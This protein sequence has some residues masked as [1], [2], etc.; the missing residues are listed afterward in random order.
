MQ[1]QAMNNELIDTLA[2][3]K[4]VSGPDAKGNYLA[5]C[6]A[7]DDGSPSLGIAAGEQVGLV[8]HCYAGCPQ[9]AVLA[10][11]R[12]LRGV[13][14]TIP[15]RSAPPVASSVRRAPKCYSTID[16]AEQ[17]L[18]RVLKGKV[19]TWVYRSGTGA[20][21]GAVVRIDSA[22]GKT[23]RPL[24]KGS[25][26]WSME[27]MREPR[28]LFQLPQLLASGVGSRV[29]I[30]EGERCAQALRELGLVAV[31]WAGGA[32]AVGKADWSPLRLMGS[33]PYILPDNDEAGE[34]AA[35][36][37]VSNLREHG[38]VVAHIVRLP[39]V[40]KGDD[41]I[42]WLALGGSRETLEQIAAASPAIWLQPPPPSPSN[43]SA[44][45]TDDAEREAIRLYEEERE[46]EIATADGSAT[47]RSASDARH[48][49]AD[50]LK[51]LPLRDQV[52]RGLASGL[53]LDEIPAWRD[54]VVSDTTPAGRRYY[55]EQSLTTLPPVTWLIDGVIPQ[56][57][58]SMLV[59]PPST[60]KSLHVLEMAYC[61]THERPWRGRRVRGGGVLIYA[62]E[63]LS[64]WNERSHAYRHRHGLPLVGKH[65]IGWIGG[66]PNLSDPAWRKH[67]IELDILDWIKRHG[68]P[69]VMVVIDTVSVALNGLSE[70][71]AESIAPVLRDLREIA[72]RYGFSWLLIHHTG[73]AVQGQPLSGLD[74]IR[75]SST[76]AG[77]LDAIYLLKPDGA[78][79][80]TMAALKLSEGARSD[81]VTRS[82][83]AVGPQQRRADDGTLMVRED[84]QPLV[85]AYVEEITD[86][87][88]D[89]AQDRRQ[90]Q[91]RETIR[92]AVI[93]YMRQPQ[94]MLVG[95]AGGQRAL[96]QAVLRL[97]PDL[98]PS[99]VSSEVAQLVSEE[100]IQVVSLGR[101]TSLFIASAA[102]DARRRHA[103][104]Q[105][106][107]LLDGIRSTQ[108]SS[109]RDLVAT[110]GGRT[111]SV[112]KRVQ[113]LA[114]TG[115]IR[116]DSDGIW[117]VSDHGQ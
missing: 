82:L 61:L 44:D 49:Q 76:F 10:A 117:R 85:S 113:A 90:T 54:R 70:N 100:A 6:P 103:E 15:Y 52:I 65:P 39:L 106:R 78:N 42:D 77:N 58:M 2:L 24:C 35:Q 110:L 105:Q 48:A 69:P 104:A 73:K 80:V 5:C 30:V 109:I 57:Q 43:P 92:T 81:E 71:D 21:V 29:F 79:I 26:G 1:A 32:K 41:V 115:E 83:I 20:E 45:D 13:G 47:K 7:H 68:R 95:V 28:P 25:F 33:I 97:S 75:G 84:G 18:A 101:S 99:E 23:Y 40:A 17:A 72:E 111:E 66:C 12:N 96:V 55:D 22:T 19:T 116:Q 14:P 59:A 107:Q 3:L 11:I 9:S 108:C 31:T 87:E 98:R 34:Q 74:S 8:V 56:G 112:L 50:Q 63:R 60:G 51:D 64:G 89:A 93:D 53:T 38:C 16:A 62:G 67:E 37:V 86:E 102:E 88:A 94:Q 114:A 91:A 36:E 4:N 27:A 46:Q